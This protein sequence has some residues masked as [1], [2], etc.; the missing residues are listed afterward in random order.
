M[1]VDAIG[2]F[3]RIVVP[4]NRGFIL[5]IPIK[6]DDLG[7]PLFSETPISNFFGKKK[8]NNNTF[9]EPIDVQKKNIL[10]VS[11]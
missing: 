11:D 8:G 6:M 4:Q 1:F 7:V 9:V 5:E 10:G 2:V 3:P